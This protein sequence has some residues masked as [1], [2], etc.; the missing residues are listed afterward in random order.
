MNA[1]ASYEL[2]QLWERGQA[3]HPLDRALLALSAALPDAAGTV[4]DWPLGR[5]NRGLA[6]MYSACF[7]PILRGWVA[8]PQCAQRLEFEMDLR[9]LAGAEESTAPIVV[10]GC[11]YRLP[12]SRDLA[13][14]AQAA[15]PRLAI[16]EACCVDGGPAGD[17]PSEEAM[18]EVERCMAAAD[19]L[20]ET[21]L[22]FECAACLNRWN[23]T[24]DLASF[25][26]AGIHARARRLIREVHAL[27]SA[28]QWSE[29]HILRMSDAR[30]AAYLE[31]VQA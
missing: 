5:R 9:V 3:L 26:W 18:V 30:R 4:A 11:T 12:C 15:E 17:P 7:D 31:L 23:D 10:G 13:L 2:L 8:C 1:L 16:M 24:L 25:V 19:P 20:A 14:A 27:A 6:H 21:V 22:D 29:D 28:Y